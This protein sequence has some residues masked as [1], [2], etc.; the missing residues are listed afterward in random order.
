[1]LHKLTRTSKAGQKTIHE[2]RLGKK[3]LFEAGITGDTVHVQFEQG[4][5]VIRPVVELNYTRREK[6]GS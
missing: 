3:W 1:M 2:L 4:A 5:I 6:R